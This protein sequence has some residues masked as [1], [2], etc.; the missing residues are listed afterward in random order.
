VNAIAEP[1]ASHGSLALPWRT[2][3]LAAGA[4]AA[5]LVFGAAPGD[6]V[7]DRVAI[8][9]GALLLLGV[10]FEERLQWR[11]PVALLAA[12][13]GVD[14]WLW[15]GDPALHYYCGLSGILNGLM[16][17]G[18]LHL[19][20]DLRHPLVLLTVVGAALKIIVE[21]N[22]GQALLTRTAWPSVP[23][24][25]AAGFVSGLVYGVAVMNALFPK[26]IPS[27]RREFLL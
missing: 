21:I 5:Y 3:L 6:W 26:H 13:V 14:A 18:L 19:W 10:L 4:V 24:A 15:W 7:F 20:R 12:T 16:I 1:A 25:H 22:T 23:A 8:A 17:V 9:I 11:L 27:P 2:I